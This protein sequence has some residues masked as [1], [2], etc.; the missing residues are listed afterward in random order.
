MGWINCD[1]FYNDGREKVALDFEGLEQY[2]SF[3]IQI[4][5]PKINSVYSL[6]SNNRA[7]NIPI[8]ES[9]KIVFVGMKNTD[10]FFYNKSV[11]TAKENKI[12]FAE[13][14]KIKESDLNSYIENSL[15]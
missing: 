9:I 3:N 13:A 5:F 15:N 6:N 12:Q 7:N 10:V 8:D 4:I 2:T 1:R 14:T 11:T